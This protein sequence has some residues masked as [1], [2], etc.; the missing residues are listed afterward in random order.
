MNRLP[1]FAFAIFIFFAV[2]AS[3]LLA[4]IAS[5]HH[6]LG[7]ELSP[8]FELLHSFIEPFFFASSGASLAWFLRYSAKKNDTDKSNANKN[9]IG[10]LK[11]SNRFTSTPFRVLCF[12]TLFALLLAMTSLLESLATGNQAGGVGM[13]F[14]LYDTIAFAVIFALTSKLWGSKLLHQRFR[15]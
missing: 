2:F 6:V 14:L 13:L 1:P 12:S 5:A 15:L 9:N 4:P 11:R 3:F 7:F 10:K 8:T